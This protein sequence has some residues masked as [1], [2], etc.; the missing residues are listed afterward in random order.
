MTKFNLISFDDKRQ[1]LLDEL[2]RFEYV[3]FS[4]TSDL[5]EEKDLENVELPMPIRENE[6]ELSQVKWLI[7]LLEPRADK[8]GMLKSLKEGL[9]W[10]SVDELKEKGS[11]IDIGPLYQDLQEKVEEIESKDQ[12]IKSL[13]AS[14]EDLRPWKTLEASISELSSTSKVKVL[15]GTIP[16]RR[17]DEASKAI[18]DLDEV[19]LE[20]VSRDS[21]NAYVI[22]IILNESYNEAIEALRQKGFNNAS[23]PG[24]KKPSEEIQNLEDQIESLKEDI[25]SLEEDISS[26]AGNLEDLKLRYEYLANKKLELSATEKF[27]DLEGIDY[28]RGYIPSARVSEFTDSLSK[29]LGSYYYLELED[30]NKKDDSTPVLL[31]NNK[32]VEPY[33]SLTSMYSTPKYS[34]V[35]PTPFFFIFYWVFFGMMVADFGYGAVMAIITGLAL[36]SFNLSASMRSSV[37]FFFM[38]S[39]STMIWGLI[40]SSAFGNSLP[41]EPLIDT[42]NYVGML[43]LSIVMGAVH[44]FFG[45]GVKAYMYIRD[46]KVKD[47]IYDVVFWYMALVGVALVLLGATGVVSAT[48]KT[49]GLVVMIIGMVGIILFAGREAKSIPARLVLGVYDLYGISSWVGDFISYSRLMALGLSGGFIAMAI[50]MI[51]DM[52]PKGIVGIIAGVVIFLIGHAFNIFL[53]YLS[54]YV[55][56]IRLTYVEFFGKFYEGGGKAFEK[57]RNETKYI[58][59][60]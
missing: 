52:M 6:E 1:A 2:Q 58:N 42:S 8:K 3:H 13:R 46:G 43:I 18:E 35:D 27:V 21:K 37:K 49:I 16:V 47:A 36:K 53:S 45:L 55:H 20:L 38:L 41:Y 33:Q 11:A 44:L 25:N 31:E 22:G 50:N 4:D 34:E 28:I 12:E 40:Y 23:I 48:L 57:F 30:A 39:I 14:L 19:Y 29:L 26:K 9:D 10:Y 7:S 32:L 60:K 59:L 51:I 56:D 5:R 17:F 15:T 24:K 54:A